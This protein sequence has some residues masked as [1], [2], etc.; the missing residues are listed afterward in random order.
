MAVGSVGTLIRGKLIRSIG[1]I[2]RGQLSG[3]DRKYYNLEPEATGNKREVVG[4]F[5][6]SFFLEEEGGKDQG[7]DRERDYRR[8]GAS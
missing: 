4:Y 1:K 3:Y 6:T 7:V 8:Q 2:Y 5:L